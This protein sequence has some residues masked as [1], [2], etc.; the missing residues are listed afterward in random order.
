MLPVSIARST[1][2]RL[3]TLYV[4]LFLVSFFVANLV[5]YQMIVSFLYERLDSHVMERYREI[6]AS[7]DAR[8]MEGAISMIASHG[9]AIRDQ[10]T[11][12][13][14]TDGNG[15]LVEGNFD[16]SGAPPGFSTLTPRVA[17]GAV[18]NYRIFSRP[19][20]N[21]GLAV[22]VSYDDTNRLR[23][24][25]LLSFGLATSIVLAAGLG[26]GTALALTARRRI[27]R[28]SEIMKAVGSG[29]LSARLPVSS[30]KDD[31]DALA[32]EVNL[33]LEQLQG[34]VE[35]MKQVTTDIAHDLKTPIGR[36]YLVIEAALEGLGDK[37]VT[38]QNLEEALQEV[39]QITRTF[40]AL[41]RISQIEA[42]A[43]KAKFVRIGLSAFLHEVFEIYAPIAEDAGRH[44]HLQHQETPDTSITGDLELLHQMC[45]NLLGNAIRHTHLGAE[46]NIGCSVSAG[47]PTITVSDN[48]PGIPVE[49]RQSVFKRF[50]RLEKSRTSEGSGLGLSVVR[51]IADLHGAEVKLEDNYPGLIVRVSFPVDPHQR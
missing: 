26:G 7:F 12:Y 11:L 40:D 30:R 38:K 19:L 9:P 14:L 32:A 16:I 25:A 45:A 27:A 20:G 48:G 5:A 51:A 33:A 10:E 44:L 37:A 6:E 43:R 15:A 2:F 35:A 1:S 4:S 13:S 39:E 28:L 49:E 23:D 47:H 18:S 46:I 21:Y 36:L 8:G 50:Y 29:E 41:L 24:I 3:A 42:G 17:T 31:I 34:S 22:G